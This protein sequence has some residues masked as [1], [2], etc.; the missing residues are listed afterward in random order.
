M[1]NYTE[2]QRLVGLPPWLRLYVYRY[3]LRR[4]KQPADVLLTL[5]YSSLEI[6]NRCFG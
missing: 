3:S 6:T 2:S 4:E 1:R 5:I